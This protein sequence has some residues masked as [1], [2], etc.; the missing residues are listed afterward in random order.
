MRHSPP[1]GV[2]GPCGG[3]GL[4]SRGGSICR[5]LG[6]G[7]MDRQLRVYRGHQLKGC[8]QGHRLRKCPNVNLDP[9]D[10]DF[11]G[12]DIVTAKRRER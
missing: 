3:P 4:A 8:R 1:Q 9:I 7:N 10:S 6:G 12:E 11:F 5:T 2:N